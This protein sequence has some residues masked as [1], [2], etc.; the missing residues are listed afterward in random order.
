MPSAD[1]AEVLLPLSDTAVPAASEP[2]ERTITIPVA[3]PVDNVDATEPSEDVV[4]VALEPEEPVDPQ[5]LDSLLAFAVRTGSSDLLLAARSVPA[6]RIDGL[7]VPIPGCDPLDPATI[8]TML[9]GTGGGVR[10]RLEGRHEVRYAYV[11]ADSHRFRVEVFEQGSALSAVFRAIPAEVPELASL[12]LA[13]MLDHIA[14]LS[15]GLVIIGGPVGSGR[16]TTVAAI[17]GAANRSRRCHVLTVEEPIEV[18]HSSGT[19]I[20]SQ[21]EIGVDVDSLTSALRSAG[22][23]GADVLVVGDLVDPLDVELA[24][25]AAEGGLLVLATAT[26]TTARGVVERLVES[27]VAR[28]QPQLRARLAYSLQAIVCQTLCAPI[29]GRGRVPA[30]E[31]LVATD[32]I[33]ELIRDG[34]FDHLPQAMAEGSKVEMHTLNQDLNRLV[35]DQ[36]I[37]TDVALERC[38]NVTELRRLLAAVG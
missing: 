36:R 22:R 6:T 13:S 15:S 34:R 23:L 35:R 16:S 30:T 9:D 37:S 10:G 20:V 29:A 5:S 17:V 32:S 26:S 27:V 8:E 3:P 1:R 7:L 14:E 12:G 21:R 28:Q 31:V 19:S 24:L 33:R 38:S 11:T 25:T 2:A 4:P 18:V